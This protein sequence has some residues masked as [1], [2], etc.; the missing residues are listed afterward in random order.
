M[1]ASNTDKLSELLALYMV[2]EVT[3]A[4]LQNRL[5][6]Y[7]VHCFLLMPW[8]LQPEHSNSPRY[9]EGAALKVPGM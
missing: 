7:C 2:I 4:N 5:N 9:R 6:L 8:Q 1:K 3:K